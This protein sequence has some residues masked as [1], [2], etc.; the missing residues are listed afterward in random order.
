MKKLESLENFNE[1]ELSETHLSNVIG[2]VAPSGAGYRATA[3]SSTGCYSYT[4]D[5]TDGDSTTYIGVEE[6]DGSNCD[7][8][9]GGG[10]GTTPLPGRLG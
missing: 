8:S 7:S 9:T 5:T 1:N 6:V 3:A 4:S 2:G 10:G